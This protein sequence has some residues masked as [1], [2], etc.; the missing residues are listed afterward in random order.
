VYAVTP[1]F[2]AALRG[3]HTAVITCDAWRDGDLIASELPVLDGSVTVDGT[4]QVRRQ[5]DVTLSPDPGLWDTLA[6]V[7]TQLRVSRGV[8]YGDGS[9]EIVPL[10]VF[11]IDVQNLSYAADGA[12][13]ITAPDQWVTVQ[14]ARFQ[15]PY[16]AIPATRII[17]QITAL[18]NGA[19]GPAWPINITATSTALVG[20]QTWDRDRDKAIADLA[21][22]IGAEAFLD[23]IGTAVLRDL[24]DADGTPVWT[25]DA[26]GTGIFAGATRSRDRQRT[27]SAVVVQSQNADGST[28]LAP[29]TISDTNPTSPTYVDGPFGF[30]PYFYSSEL[31]R[32]TA[33]MT[34]A[35]RKLLPKVTG[36]Q[37][38]LNLD[39]ATV[40][41]ALDAGDVLAVLLPPE[42]PLSARPVET[43]II[44][45]VTIPLTVTAGQSMQTRALGTAP[46]ET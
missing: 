19:L 45:Q 12:L 27:Y 1:Q 2:L 42:S 44:D 6:P 14:R 18:I 38:Q 40:N 16:V 7:G 8:R 21:A 36:L 13:Q 25:V 41:P 5:L 34:S 33:Q 30:V 22:S 29:V 4:A 43:H 15:T 31:L 28:R 10:G 32:T 20:R 39:A 3:P 9:T 46:E 17:P 35:G 26:G 24:P 37:S 23:P 11:P